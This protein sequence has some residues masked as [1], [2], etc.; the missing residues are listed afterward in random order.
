MKRNFY[1]GFLVPLLA[2]IFI[3]VAGLPAGTQS[4]KTQTA[5]LH[6]YQ[7]DG[8]AADNFGQVVFSPGD[9]NKNG[10]TDLLIGVPGYDSSTGQV[11]FYNG[12]ANMDSIPDMVFDGAGNGE[13]FGSGL[14]AGDFN[15]DMNLDFVVG[16]PGYN[17]STGKVNLYFGG[18]LLNTSV[19]GQFGGQSSGELFGKAVC[20]SD[21]VNEDGYADII[22]GAPGFSGS[23]GKVYVFYGGEIVDNIPDLVMTGETA[24]DQFGSSI[25]V[26]DVNMD[27]FGDIV[28]GAPGYNGGNGKLYL[29]L[30][31]G[32][33]D[34]Q[35]DWVYSST[36]SG[37]GLGSSLNSAGF[38][39]ED[40]FEDL[41]AGAAAYNSNVGR[42][43][44]FYGNGTLVTTPSLTMSGSFPGDNFGCSVSKLGDVNEDDFSDLIIGASGYTGGTGRA[45]IY[46]GGNA[47][48]GLVDATFD[49]DLA[50]S[51]FGSTVAAGGDLDGDGVEDIVVSASAARTSGQSYL[52]LGS[53]LTAPLTPVFMQA[54]GGNAQADLFWRPNVETD[55][56]R[57]YI[58]GDTLENPTV[59]MDSTSAL[60]RLD[61]NKTVSG[62]IN[63]KTYFFRITAKDIARNESSYSDPM[64]ATPSEPAAL[65]TD[66]QMPLRFVV[67]QNYPNPFNP[68]TVVSFTLPEAA[69]V[70]VTL[71]DI[72]GQQVQSK[73]LGQQVIGTHQWRIDGSTLGSG[74]YFYRVRAKGAQAYSATRRMLLLR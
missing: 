64:Q 40:G 15:D 68:T 2:L 49:G 24:G 5:D 46:Y 45:S 60:N 54:I 62:L 51:S 33:I 53:D 17:G 43:Y 12:S 26:L 73:Y 22:V 47:P 37:E 44:V 14:G 61:T 63:G 30:G 32:S 67:Q 58:Y 48:D 16:V 25:C 11:Y 50:S 59:L 1:Q 71:Y 4:L 72:L 18:A 39:N 29:F 8:I 27:G 28:V 65:G 31:D 10:T 23:T 42:A 66:P 38:F 3:W 35:A 9:L 70:T 69:R 7:G 19:D 55:F 41:I 56:Y 21:D 6:F 74:V 13:L 57:Y 34:N 36:N 52:F 20:G